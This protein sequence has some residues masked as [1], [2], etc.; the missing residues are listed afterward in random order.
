MLRARH[1]VL[2]HGL[3]MICSKCSFKCC[4]QDM[5]SKQ[6]SIP[7]CSE[8]SCRGVHARVPNLF[9]SFELSQILQR[10]HGSHTIDIQNQVVMCLSCAAYA[11]SAKGMA[12][13]HLRQVCSHHRTTGGCAR[14]LRWEKGH[15]PDQGAWPAL[16]LSPE[17]GLYGSCQLGVGVFF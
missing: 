6:I 10:L 11:K 4:V 15:C 13:S 3:H 7:M 8:L 5:M 2:V 16:G 1:S 17:I 14:L 12:K 9:I